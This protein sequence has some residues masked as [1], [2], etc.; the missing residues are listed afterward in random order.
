MNRTTIILTV[1]FLVLAGNR[2]SAQ[3]YLKDGQ[4]TQQ[5]KVVQLQ[6][7]FAGFTGVQFTI[8]R[9]GS[10]TSESVFNQKITPKSRGK[11]TEKD[12]AKLGAILVKY[13]LAKLPAK[14]GKQPGA[15]PHTI[16]FEYGK[17]KASLVGQTPPKLDPKNPTGAVESRFAGIWEG[18]V[19]LLT[20]KEESK[21]GQDLANDNAIKKDRKQIEGTWRIVA[22]EVN[23][24][25]AMDE[26][27]KKLAVVNGSDGSWSLRSEDKEISKG[28]S[29]IDPTKKLK[30]IDFTPTEGAG[31]DNFYLGIYEL[32]EKTRKLCFAPPGK[33]RPTEFSSTP[34][35]EIVLVTFEREKGK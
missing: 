15:N 26:D 19:G 8:T 35:S 2:L 7:G 33:E 29:T 18:V 10:W 5:L 22:L 6:G 14:S 4:L 24:N 17:M 27:A 1:T 16:T 20:P 21:E 3:D 9:D 11:L 13:D 30:T 12:L 34:G 23:G 31:K 32:G 25:K 28:T